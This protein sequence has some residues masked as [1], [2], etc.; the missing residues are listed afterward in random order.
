MGIFAIWKS[1]TSCWVIFITNIFSP[2][3]CV[4]RGA[5][6]NPLVNGCRQT[7]SF[8]PK[9]SMNSTPRH[10]SDNLP[11]PKIFIICFPPISRTTPAFSL[12][13][14]GHVLNKLPCFFGLFF[15]N[16]IRVDQKGVCPLTDIGNLH[17][18]F[19]QQLNGAL[20]G[21]SNIRS[22]ALHSIPCLPA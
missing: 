8:K 9:I 6:V 18:K 7:H 22:P 21:Y 12:S 1:A 19:R 17:C 5:L 20:L 4:V 11:K 15:S 16:N 2:I 14:C 10:W 13:D 3:E